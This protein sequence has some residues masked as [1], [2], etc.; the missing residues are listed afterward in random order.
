MHA[1][2]LHFPQVEDDAWIPKTWGDCRRTGGK[3]KSYAVTA[4]SL[5]GDAVYDKAVF[6]DNRFARSHQLSGYKNGE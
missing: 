2:S 1:K 3:S 5:N 6:A 4:I